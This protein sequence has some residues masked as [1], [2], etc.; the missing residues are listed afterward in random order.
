MDIF[1]LFEIS[2][3][4]IKA[5]AKWTNANVK[6]FNVIEMIL[7]FRF[8]LEDKISEEHLEFFLLCSTDNKE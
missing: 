3:S 6:E 5:S 4:R 2:Q 1:W 7:E 8:S